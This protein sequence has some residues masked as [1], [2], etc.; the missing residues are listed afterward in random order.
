M[1]PSSI[2]SSFSRGASASA[3]RPEEP[4]A[5]A[6]ARGYGERRV[7]RLP[8]SPAPACRSARARDLDL[9]SNSWKSLRQGDLGDCYFLS[10][11][12]GLAKQR[13]RDLEH[14]V[15][16]CGNQWHVQF[17]RLRPVQV[18][19]SE[20]RKGVQADGRWASVLESAWQKASGHL[21]RSG[22]VSEPGGDPAQAIEALT[23]NRARTASVSER[24]V[25][26]LLT[27]VGESLERGGIA[28]A[29]TGSQVTQGLLPD[30]A[31]TILEA[32]FPDR[33]V[34]RNPWGSAPYTGP[35][36]AG[37]Q[38]N[39]WGDGTFAMDPKAF[40]RGFTDLYYEVRPPAQGRQPAG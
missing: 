10:A 38:V 29:A 37:C 39:R 34:L 40:A 2:I 25:G 36:P 12:G 13:P 9:K 32:R 23:G 15:R 8:A 17:Y 14:L 3:P 27:Q 4:G 20:I 26:Y 5:G 11:L 33:I 19:G 35:E 7:Q 28:V 21:L 16:V 22:R 1:I 6:P 30:H 31:Y 24:N 18:T